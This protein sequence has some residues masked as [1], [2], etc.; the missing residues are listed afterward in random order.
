[1]A[2]DIGAQGHP[3]KA[4]YKEP[5][6]LAEVLLREGTWR[7]LLKV[8]V[9]ILLLLL[10][11]WSVQLL[12]LMVLGHFGRILSFL[13]IAVVAGG[14]SVLAVVPWRFGIAL[15]GLDLALPLV[16]QEWV[17]PPSVPSPREPAFIAFCRELSRQLRRARLRSEE[18]IRL[19]AG[20]VLKK[21]VVA[22]LVYFWLPL[23]MCV[24]LVAVERLGSYRMLDP[25]RMDATSF[26]AVG[27]LMLGLIGLA[28]L[29]LMSFEIWWRKN[30]LAWLRGE[31]EQ[32]A[33]EWV[34]T[35]A[36]LEPRPQPPTLA[37][38]GYVDRTSVD[39]P[40]P[41]APVPEA[42]QP[43]KPSDDFQNQ[44]SEEPPLEF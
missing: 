28:G 32:L 20:S 18:A 12:K 15:W 3:Y 2:E 13:T 36:Q 16:P 31:E 24:L 8:F 1:M 9:G 33:F 14:S 43:E 4:L 34:T 38:G 26:A 17:A 22:N 40:R 29:S 41:P 11:V 27:F 7:I 25:D 6:K 23:G 44:E 39:V 5:S 21:A 19:T 42:A 10:A 30:F 37:E 35:P